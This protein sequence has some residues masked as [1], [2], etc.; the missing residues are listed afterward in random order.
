VGGK[1]LYKS[2]GPGE[3]HTTLQSN[4]KGY[5]IKEKTGRIATVRPGT[6][7]VEGKIVPPEKEK[8][9]GERGKK[10]QQVSQEIDSVGRNGM[11]GKKVKRVK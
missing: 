9:K 2:R 1:T 8:G 10:R 4:E 7:A 11:L 5:P 3:E 6:V